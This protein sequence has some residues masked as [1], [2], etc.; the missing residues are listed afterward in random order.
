MIEVCRVVIFLDGT[1][2]GL[3][4]RVVPIG[5]WVGKALISPGGGAGGA[6]PGGRSGGGYF[7]GPP[8]GVTEPGSGLDGG[9]IAATMG[10]TVGSL[11]DDE[12]MGQVG[13][14]SW[15]IGTDFFNLLVL[16]VPAAT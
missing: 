13:S 8:T 5:N 1:G 14:C 11:L 16:S 3:L 7:G 10:L 12:D 2:G 4:G 9:G 15:D 6:T